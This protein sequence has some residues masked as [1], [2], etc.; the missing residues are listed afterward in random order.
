MYAVQSTRELDQNGPRAVKQRKYLH[1]EKLLHRIKK[2]LVAVNK[3]ASKKTLQ[4]NSLI[5]DFTKAFHWNMK[6]GISV[7][8]N[9][10]RYFLN[11]L[12]SNKKLAILH[13]SIC[14]KRKLAMK[15]I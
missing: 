13:S 3:K 12:L 15:T 4:M 11:K 9:I 8:D 14:Y 1:F 6:V 5:F 7:E 2:F 10:L